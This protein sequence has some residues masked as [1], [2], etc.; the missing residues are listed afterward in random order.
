VIAAVFALFHN[1]ITW[2]YRQILATRHGM[3]QTHSE[4]QQELPHNLIIGMIHSSFEG[5]LADATF[6]CSVL[7]MSKVT[8]SVV[9][10]SDHGAV[11]LKA[12][13]KSYLE[14]LGYTVDDLGTHGSESVDYPDSSR[15][16]CEAF[17]N[18]GYEFG[19]VACGTGIGVS[20]AANKIKGIRCALIHDPFT[21]EMAK[22]HNDANVIALGGRVSYSHPLESIL[23][24]YLNAT[25]EGGRH[26][27]RVGKINDLDNAN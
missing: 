4:N 16:V 2:P 10:G 21:A 8:K 17:L 14:K 19:I 1:K 27:R 5:A 12:N 3:G 24:A 9:I 18:G 22:A 20:M 26:S 13:I 15:A 23:D 11:E 6:L 7:G 25:F